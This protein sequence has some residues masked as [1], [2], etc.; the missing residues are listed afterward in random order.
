MRFDHSFTLYW[1]LISRCRRWVPLFTLCTVICG[2]SFFLIFSSIGVLLSQIVSAA[3]GSGEPVVL[4]KVFWYLLMIFMSALLGGFSMSGF[5]YLEQH[6]RHNLRMEMLDRYL[7]VSEPVAA[8]YPPV[9]IQNRINYDIPKSTDLIGYLMSGWVFQP[10][11]SGSLSLLLLLFVDWRVALLCVG[12]SAVSMGVMHLATERLRKLNEAMTEGRSRVVC[13]LEECIR[14]AVEIRT[15]GLHGLFKE[16]LDTQLADIAEATADY[17]RLEGI[18]RSV[19][20]FLADCITIVSLLV[21]GAFL[22]SRNYIEFSLIMLSLPLSDQIAQAMVAVVNFPA[23]V[24]EGSPNVERLFEILDLQ[25]EETEKAATRSADELLPGKIVFQDVSFSYG[26]SL[27]LDHFTFQVH[28]GEKVA[29]VGESGSG[30]STILKLLLG[31]Y[32]PDEGSI[33]IGEQVLGKIPLSQWRRQLAYVPQE[34]SLFHRSVRQNISLCLEE[35]T[36][37]KVI[38]AAKEAGADSFLTKGRSIYEAVLGEQN[39]GFSGGQLQRIS[40]ARALYKRAPIILLD[41]PTSAMDRNSEEMIRDVIRDLPCDQTVIAV[42]HRLEL[43]T[44]FDCLY[45][46]EK[47]TIAEKGSHKELLEQHGIYASLWEAQKEHN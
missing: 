22:A 24:R 7:H 3:S 20:T 31:F 2:A 18:R 6:I 35:G 42:T 12:C 25:I 16:K 15:F 26:Q 1:R 30:K 45:V 29:F 34:L 21:L 43:T 33:S 39:S 9:E 19:L 11:L 4:E 41:E 8:A 5:I 44:E 32:D 40:L 10:L 14:G 36:E 17:R 37:E 46:M 23:M 27:I 13:F 38:L 47:G 28:P